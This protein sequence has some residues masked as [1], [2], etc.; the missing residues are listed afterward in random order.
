VLVQFTIYPM[1]GTHMSK[2]VAA[3]VNVL[4]EAGVD[5]RLGPMGTAVEGSWDKV[6]PAIHQCHELMREMH[7]RVITTITIDDRKEHPHHLDEMVSVVEQRLGHAARK[8]PQ[9][10]FTP[11]F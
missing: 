1:D 9:P 3:I 5:Y 2:A 8:V 11:E 4:D 7:P 10:Q 6:L